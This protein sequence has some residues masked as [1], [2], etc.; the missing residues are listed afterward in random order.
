MRTARINYGPL[1]KIEEEAGTVIACCPR[2]DG[3]H[4]TM[5][6]RT[7]E[8]NRSSRRVDCID[9][10]WK[11]RWIKEDKWERWMCDNVYSVIGLP[12]GYTPPKPKKKRKRRKK[13]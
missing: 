6:T 1:Y 5:E 9:C 11:G 13:R 12:E 4:L 2:C 8:Q 7:S 3:S 10:G